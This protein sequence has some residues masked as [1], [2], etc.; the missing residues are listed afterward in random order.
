MG[1]GCGMDGWMVLG[2]VWVMEVADYVWGMGMDGDG[3]GRGREMGGDV[4][5]IYWSDG[6]VEGLHAVGIDVGGMDVY[7]M[8]HDW[9]WRGMGWDVDG[10]LGLMIWRG[11]KAGWMGC[12]GWNG[13][14][15]VD[16]VG[17]AV[18]MGMMGRDGWM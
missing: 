2:H 3:D 18:V 12:M 10:G 13:D 7:G 16:R 9:G 14:D 8:V 17:G 11:M 6:L 4:W 15:V 5:V 1:C